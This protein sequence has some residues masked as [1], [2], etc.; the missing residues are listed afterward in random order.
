MSYRIQVRELM[1]EISE[2]IIDANR[3]EKRTARL[4]LGD[5]YLAYRL[6]HAAARLE[7]LLASA[8]RLRAAAKRAR[9]K[10]ERR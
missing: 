5:R 7:R 6:K 1:A 8:R 2:A 4:K 10:A 9:R 3:L